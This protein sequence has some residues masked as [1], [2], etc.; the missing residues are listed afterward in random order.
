MSEFTSRVRL[1]SC[2]FCS[3]QGIDPL[4]N[5]R[6]TDLETLKYRGSRVGRGGSQGCKFFSELLS[7]STV[8]LDRE[9]HNGSEYSHSTSGVD[10]WTYYLAV[11]VGTNAGEDRGWGQW[12]KSPN[13]T[14]LSTGSI[15]TVLA[16]SGMKQNALPGL[17][18]SDN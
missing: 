5:D 1:H 3:V 11:H 15:Y 14:F 18:I 2:D 7:Q 12:R 4:A 6:L 9:I 13:E 17:I 8:R 16:L 10:Q